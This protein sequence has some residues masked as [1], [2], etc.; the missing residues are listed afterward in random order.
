MAIENFEAVI[1]EEMVQAGM[2]RA[3]ITNLLIQVL[4]LLSG[5]SIEDI[6][7]ECASI[8]VNAESGERTRIGTNI[9]L[10]QRIASEEWQDEI[11][12]QAAALQ[13]IGQERL[14][15]TKALLQLARLQQ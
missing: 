12:S 3:A 13:A 11:S 8:Q 2:E 14:D 1:L 6:Q 15:R 7:N 5:V 9:L 10:R 4:S